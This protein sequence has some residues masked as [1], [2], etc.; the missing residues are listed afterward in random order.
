VSSQPRGK[1]N[2]LGENPNQR[3]GARRKTRYKCRRCGNSAM[4]VFKGEAVV[5]QLMDWTD[6]ETGYVEHGEP[7]VKHTRL[8]RRPD[9]CWVCKSQDIGYAQHTEGEL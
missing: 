2:L 1:M 4:F 3:S 5:M 7:I 6:R 8:E 9:H